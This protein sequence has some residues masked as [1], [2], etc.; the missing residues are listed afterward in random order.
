MAF[1]SNEII[2]CG[3]DAGCIDFKRQNVSAAYF[4][5]IEFQETGFYA[6]RLQRAAFGKKSREATRISLAQ[7]LTDAGAV[8]AG[9]IIGQNGAT[10]LLEQ[11][12]QN[13]A[14]QVV[15][16]S[17]F[18]SRFPTSLSALD[19]VNALF[20]SAGVVPTQTE[21]QNAINA[22]GAGDTAGRTAALRQVAESNSVTQAELNPSFVLMQYFGYL[23]RDPDASGYDFWLNK[24]EQ[25]NGNY[26]QAEM[27]K[28]FSRVRRI[29]RTLP[30]PVGRRQKA[31]SRRQE[32][33]QERGHMQE[34]A[35]THQGL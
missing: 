1:W 2:S 32:Q 15:S 11:N 28:S 8:G 22:F 10:Q 9:V 12:K 6:I 26:I 33:R 19:F 24:L 3:T 31:V 34:H 18:I 25:F 4:L 35:L 14:A 27:V 16:S 29:P 7:F 5:S 21:L 20:N 23:R 30:E 13:Y 17:A